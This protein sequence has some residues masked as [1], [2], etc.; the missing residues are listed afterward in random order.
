M[1]WEEHVD[2]IWSRA[3]IPEYA[4]DAKAA[5]KSLIRSRF[6]SKEEVEKA[7]RSEYSYIGACPTG[8]CGHRNTDPFSV[9]HG[10]HVGRA[11]VLDALKARLLGG[12]VAH[13][14]E[15]C[16]W[17]SDE[18]GYWSPCPAHSKH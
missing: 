4:N 12:T 8:F 10:D 7:I 5:I 13:D 11:A 3:E 9:H 17:R 16:R 1:T 14:C 18:I 6:M 15:A 2:L